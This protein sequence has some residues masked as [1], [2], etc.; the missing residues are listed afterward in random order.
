M[1]TRQKCQLEQ[2]P[3]HKIARI[4][5]SPQ[6]CLHCPKL[7]SKFPDL[8]S[9]LFLPHLLLPSLT[10]CD[11]PFWHDQSLPY[12]T[13]CHPTWK[14]TPLISWSVQERLRFSCWTQTPIVA[15][16]GPR[17]R[18]QGSAPG[19]GPAAA[20]LASRGRCGPGQDLGS[21][22]ANARLCSVSQSNRIPELPLGRCP[23]KHKGFQVIIVCL[24]F[25]KKG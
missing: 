11:W 22:L 23:R 14:C 25:R 5:M 3:R 19:L 18:P 9:P 4:L 10:P 21:R 6:L 2:K 8:F 13:C 16:L 17:V 12:R 7:H 20:V 1:F 24:L 15:M